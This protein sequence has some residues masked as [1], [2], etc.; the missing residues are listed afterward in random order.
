MFAALYGLVQPFG[1]LADIATSYMLKDHLH[2]SASQVSLFR[3]ITVA[4]MYV[5]FAFGLT[6]DIWNPLGRRD[7]GYFLIFGP[8]IALVFTAL[9]FLPLSYPTLLVAM[10]MAAV[11]CSFVFAAFTGLLALLGQERLMSGQLTTVWRFVNLAVSVAGAFGGG[12]LA[13]H[14]PPRVTFFLLAA[15]GLGIG[16]FGLWQPRAV[17]GGVYAKP[18]AKGGGLVDDVGRLVR[19]KAVYAP[20]LMMLL[21]QFAPGANTPLQYYLTNVVHASDAVYGEFQAIFL[22]SFAPVFLLYGW[23]CTRVTLEKLLWWGTLITVPQMIPLAFVHSATAALVLAVPMG[24]MG[25]LCVLAIWDLTMRSCPPGLQGTLMS[26]VMSVDV[27]SQRAGDVLGSWIYN[28]SPKNGFL[29]CVIAITAVYALIPPLIL[30]APKD[31]IRR[32]DGEV[33]AGPDEAPASAAPSPA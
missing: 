17:F 16:L 30:L 23:L 32:A 13:Q 9:A 29:Y 4:P 26:L 31:V 21:F 12:L 6:R 10:L 22:G 20:V 28:A 3:L 8:V 7:R 33:G 5:A 27:L 11:C 14:V 15:L 2:A 25:G 19:H 1:M 24:L 18:A